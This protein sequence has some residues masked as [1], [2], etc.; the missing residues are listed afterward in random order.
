[1]SPATKMARTV[2]VIEDLR[3]HP[4]RSEIL[5]LCREQLLDCF[6]Q[7]P[8]DLDEV[9]IKTYGEDRTHLFYEPYDD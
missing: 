6:E 3:D 2:E 8:E 7:N 4:H 5:N 1:M 9:L